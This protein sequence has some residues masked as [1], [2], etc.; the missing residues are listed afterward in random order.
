MY[1]HMLLCVH[2]IIL[3]GCGT[4]DEPTNGKARYRSTMTDAEAIY[5]CDEN[6]E[7]KGNNVRKCQKNGSW[8][9]SVPK[10]ECKSINFLRCSNCLHEL[11]RWLHQYQNN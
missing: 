2:M 3:L 11:V 10:C 8:S 6:Y 5:I 9:G 1:I 7:L 4:P